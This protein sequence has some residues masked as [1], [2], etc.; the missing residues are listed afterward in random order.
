MIDD[1]KPEIRVYHENSFIRFGKR[2]TTICHSNVL[3]LPKA[4]SGWI[5]TVAN[6]GGKL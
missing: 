3:V 1:L 4:L 2:F 6:K 5:L